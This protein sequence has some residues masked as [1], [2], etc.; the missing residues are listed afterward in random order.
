MG[1]HVPE[2]LFKLHTIN[3]KHDV[4]TSQFC[5]SRDCDIGIWFQS[6]KVRKRLSNEETLKKI[7][8]NYIFI[9]H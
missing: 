3:A 1:A 6:V 9:N 5:R 8:P 2:N 7:N 4:K